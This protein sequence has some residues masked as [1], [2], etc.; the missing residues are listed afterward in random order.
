MLPFRREGKKLK[1][2]LTYEVVSEILDPLY[3]ECPQIQNF[4]IEGNGKVEKEKIV[5]LAIA[6]ICSHIC[7]LHEGERML[8]SPNI[9]ILLQTNG[10]LEGVTDDMISW[11]NRGNYITREDAQIIVDNICDYLSKPK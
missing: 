5:T 1:N 2:Y 8:Y 9:R 4:R 10:I 3:K 6:A 7:E 11:I